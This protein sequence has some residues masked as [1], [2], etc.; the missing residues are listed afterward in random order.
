MARYR[1][2]IVIAL[3]LKGNSCR[4]GGKFYRAHGGTVAATKLF[5]AFGAWELGVCSPF[6]DN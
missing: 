1:S 5:V 4:E 6:V 2:A 3:E